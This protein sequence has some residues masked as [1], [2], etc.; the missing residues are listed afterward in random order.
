MGFD[1]AG[2]RRVLHAAT[3]QYLE[4]L[5]ET[6]PQ[7]IVASRRLCPLKDAIR[8]VHF[9]TRPGQLHDALH[10][11]KYEEFFRFQIKLAL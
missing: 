10:R 7:W 11:L 4:S 8:N 9:P 3:T 2:F 1:S 5:P 6:L